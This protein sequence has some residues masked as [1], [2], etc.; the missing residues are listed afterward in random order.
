[1]D[2]K[3]D[4]KR[5]FTTGERCQVRD[6]LLRYLCERQIG[7][8]ILHKEICRHD[9]LGR[10]IELKTLQRFLGNKHRTQDDYVSVCHEFAKTL[11][12]FGE[13]RRAAALG[14]ALSRFYDPGA[15]RDAGGPWSLDERIVLEARRLDLND[16]SAG[17]SI[18]PKELKTSDFPVYGVI[19][20]DPSEDGEYYRIYQILM[21]ASGSAQASSSPRLL[22]EGVAVPIEDHSMVTVEMD[23]LTRRPR[24]GLWIYD[25][26]YEW[27]TKVRYLLPQSPRARPDPLHR[28]DSLRLTCKPGGEDIDA[29]ADKFLEVDP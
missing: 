11:P 9:P 18:V 10:D 1:M 17:I 20:L 22:S 15:A 8:S 21:G 29:L 25:K 4:I 3:V 26:S 13:R 14:Q 19:V 28:E 6:A 27:P 7:V 5:A 12:Y 24:N 23:V 16:T 2:T